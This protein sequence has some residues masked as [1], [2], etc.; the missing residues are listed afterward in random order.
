VLVVRDQD[1]W[2]LSMRQGSYTNRG[3]TEN[4]SGFIS[5]QL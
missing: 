4:K 5:W 2:K 3:V 1:Q